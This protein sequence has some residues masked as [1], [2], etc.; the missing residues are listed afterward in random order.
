MSGDKR[1]ESG[2]KKI[3]AVVGP[4]ASGKTSLAVELAVRFSG[5][6]V[7]CD[8]MQIYRG[9]D[10]GTAKP[11]A[12][13]MRGIPHHLID[14]V[15][16][17]EDFSVADYLPLAQSA[18]GDIISRG[19]LPI[20][21]GGTGLYLDT[22]LRGGTLKESEGDL[23]LRERLRNEAAELGGEALHARLAAVDPES[24]AAI[25]PNNLRRTIRALEIYEATGIT[26]SEHDRRSR[27]PGGDYL[28]LII[29]LSF[30]SRD[31]L[32]RRI[33][34]RV[35]KM[36]AEELLPEVER[37][38]LAGVFERSRTAAQA[39]GYKELLAYIRGET[40]LAD[41]AA[42]LKR[43]TRRYAKRQMTWFMANQSVRWIEAGG[44]RCTG[45]LAEEAGEIIGAELF[46]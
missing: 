15:D 23:A 33:D 10:I 22:F 21:C 12:A 26:K 16:P 29:G 20:F 5:E 27:I 30:S 42:E 1:R 45:E 38:Y 3:I 31:E 7:S 24:A 14:I 44:G 19:R 18:A 35:D 28:P 13:E 9:L 36:L 41:A 4:T 43:A 46:N 11:T 8:S 25:H 40:S 6:V 32:Y 17:G 34:E 37:L 2:K 39:I